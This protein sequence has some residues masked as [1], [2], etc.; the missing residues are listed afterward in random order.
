MTQL[1]LIAGVGA[2]DGLG[3]AQCRRFAGAGYHVVVSGRTQS[4]LDAVAEQIETAGGSASSLVLDVTGEDAVVAGFQ[5]LDELDG[6]HVHA[7][8]IVHGVVLSDCLD[9][10]ASR[11][12]YELHALGRHRL[13]LATPPAA[14]QVAA[15]P[16]S[17]ACVASPSRSCTAVAFVLACAPPAPSPPPA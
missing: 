1:A 2:I 15:P 17:A 14:A 3:A 12:T 4:K 5:T 9:G 11:Q 7:I 8:E 13:R 6:M 16:P 10:S